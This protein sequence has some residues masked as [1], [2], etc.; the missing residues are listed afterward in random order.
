MSHFTVHINFI[1]NFSWIQFEF[2]LYTIS[3]VYSYNKEVL[4]RIVDMLIRFQNLYVYI[5]C[6]ISIK[7]SLSITLW[8]INVAGI[9]SQCFKELCFNYAANKHKEKYTF[10]TVN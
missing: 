5:H 9:H 3:F 8:I 1:P 7:R 2:W 6:L 10:H 4:F